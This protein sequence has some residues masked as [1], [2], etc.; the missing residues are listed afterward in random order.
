MESRDRLIVA[1]AAGVFEPKSEL[2]GRVGV[3][4]RIGQ[5]VGSLRCGV[6]TIAVLSPFAGT[7]RDV[8]SWQDERVRPYQPLVWLEVN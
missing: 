7:T 2:V 8:L 6:D 4:I 1:P 3:P 5:T